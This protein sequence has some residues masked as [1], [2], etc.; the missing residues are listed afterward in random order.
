MRF[1][2]TLAVISA[3]GLVAGCAGNDPGMVPVERRE[4]SLLIVG[5][6]M[7]VENAVLYQRM[8]ELG[9]APVGVLPTAS[10]VPEESGPGTVEDF[11]KNGVVASVIDVNF[12][13]PEEAAN[14]WK[15]DAIRASRSIFF[16][17]GDQTRIIDAFRPATGDTVGYLALWSVLDA[18]GVIGGTSAGAAMM[19]DPCIRWGNST[20]A[21]LIGASEAP[22]HGVRIGRGMGFFPYGLTDQHFLRRG[23]LGRMIVAQMAAGM[24]RGFGVEE[25]R[26]LQVDL[27]THTLTAVGGSRAVLVADSSTAVAD[28]LARRGIRISLLSDGD[29]MDGRRGTVTVAPDSGRALVIE[30][31]TGTTTLFPGEI[32]EPYRVADVLAT[33]AL[34]RRAEARS[35]DANFDLIFTADNRSR[36]FLAPGESDPTK[37]DFTAVS[38]NLDIIPREGADAAR[39]ELLAKI[40]S[41][42]PAN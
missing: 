34:E 2:K 6:A 12:K 28:G 21:L 41:E 19:S 15:A 22:D 17:G 25:N 8:A 3:A 5:G 26:A 13:A 1:A 16:T 40:A 31:L 30:P 29:T 27:H 11:G 42:A 20:E 35:S 14:P 4:G 36:F 32:W 38:V 10:G 33:M 18:D 39:S 9:A 7:K 37:A 24:T 23:R